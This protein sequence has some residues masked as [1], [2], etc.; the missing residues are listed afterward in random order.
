MERAMSG[1]KDSD[2]KVCCY[3]H[4]EFLKRVPV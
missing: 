1:T 3:R 2:F 4:C